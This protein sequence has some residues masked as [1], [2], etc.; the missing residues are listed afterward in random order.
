[1]LPLENVIE[2]NNDDDK[3]GRD[4]GPAE[5][6]LWKGISSTLSSSDDTIQVTRYHSLHVMDLEGTPLRPTAVTKDADAVLM[7]M[8]H[9]EYPHYGVQFHPESIGTQRV[10]KDLLRNFLQVCFDCKQLNQSTTIRT[11]EEVVNGRHGT[12]SLSAT[13]DPAASI[14]MAPSPSSSTA[15][16]PFSVYIHKVADLPP[17]GANL[18]PC[19]VMNELL[20]GEAYSFWLD[21]EASAN[22]PSSSVS[23]LGASQQRVEY[24]G[25]EQPLEQ[26][27]LFVW[28][29][30]EN[31]GM[32]RHTETDIL[33]YLQQQ[34]RQVTESACM[35]SFAVETQEAVFEEVSEE[36]LLDIVPFQ[37][38]GGH[39][40][41]LGYEVRHDTARYLEEEE[42][43]RH[44]E[45]T[46]NDSGRVRRPSSDPKIPSA[47]F[48]WADR[49][50]VYDH[51][52]G[53][54][55]L[56]G[57]VS[58]GNENDDKSRR[59]KSMLDWMR[60]T[61]AY[62]RRGRGGNRITNNPK[63]QNEEENGSETLL[64]EAPVFIP[65]RSQRTYNRNFD[66]CIEHIR[67]GESYELCLTNQL[68]ASMRVRDSS[69]LDLY[70]VLRR[71]N[72][73]PFSAFLEW[74]SQRK[75]D[76]SSPAAVAICCSSPERFVSVKRE[77]KSED[78]SSSSSSSSQQLLQV[79]AKPIKGT[80]ARV[81]PQNGRATLTE[82]ERAEDEARAHRL[83]GS[84][85]DRAENLMIVDLLRND[86][87]RVCQTG[88]VHV[89]KLMD[90][91]SFATV[92]QM[93]ST[94]RGTLD[95]C[96]QPQQ[97]LHRRG[98][99][100]VLKACFP[101]GSMTGAPKLRTM[102]LLDNIEE[103]VNRGPYSGCL[104][105]LSLNGSM[106]MNIVIRTAVLTPAGNE[107]DEWKVR[108]G[109]GGAIT[110]LSE[111]ADEYAEMMLKASAVMGAV[112]E[113]ATRV[114]G[115]RERVEL[116]DA[117]DHNDN[118]AQQQF[119]KE[120]NT[121]DALVA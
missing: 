105:Y 3:N 80:A 83:L 9:V 17:N 34:H 28:N 44:H 39:V 2:N 77:A 86:L 93:V 114:G 22:N 16:S 89:A 46:Q 76:S 94:I 51:Q 19:D 82:E 40:G 60:S 85:K 69:P 41:Y 61:A 27:G 78:R 37:F 100:D 38:R 98:A 95:S 55:F 75:D 13:A 101:G 88:S 43:G 30:Q 58:V 35:I 113:W 25:K 49:S 68:E 23:I 18:Q 59:L 31:E 72:P 1:L 111:S 56:V 90:I 106:D 14:A 65:N 112:K 5:N 84:E 99:V 79:E 117:V 12:G 57:V 64:A 50:L 21:G 15:P 62:L 66:E 96:S 120:S 70:N 91:E 103:G 104:G 118:E 33:T 36:A 74:N 6:R 29:H 45:T 63:Q 4:D 11:E 115:S 52:T 73:A 32:E 10:G 121:T 26:Q 97:Q 67:K 108:V 20:E 7:A 53:D 81:L 48:L 102:E 119:L 92:H 42:G 87:N 8:Q 107:R 71:R 110:A 47:A 54:W 116:L 109:A 24:W